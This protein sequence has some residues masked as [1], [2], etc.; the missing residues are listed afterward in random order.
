MIYVGRKAQRGVAGSK[1]PQVN[2]VKNI[3]AT[4]GSMNKVGGFPCTQF[5]PFKLGPVTD[6]IG[7][8][9]QN[10]ENYW[11]GGKKFR[12]LGHE[13]HAKWQQFRAQIYSD[14]IP[15]RR[16]PQAKTNIVR[17]VVNGKNKYVY[18]IAYSSEYLG[19]EMDYITSRKLIYAPVYARLVAQTAAFRELKSQVDRGLR[20]M[21]LDNDIEDGAHQITV[22]YLRDRINDPTKPFGHGYVLAALLA[23]FEPQQYCN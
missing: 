21:I 3:N 1:D 14:P 7:L 19:R 11:Q 16:P 15:H 22:E 23:G 6:E 8:T 17:E 5:S 4:S 10:F 9:A 12:E 18:Y 2:G 13:D 20:V